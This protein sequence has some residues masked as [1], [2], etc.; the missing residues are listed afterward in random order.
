MGSRIIKLIFKIGIEM[1]FQTKVDS[2]L[3]TEVRLCHSAT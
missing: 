2:T 3:S 1:V